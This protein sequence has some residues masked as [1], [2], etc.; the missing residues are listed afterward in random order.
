MSALQAG[1][2]VNSGWVF[3]QP[4]STYHRSLAS[5]GTYAGSA[6]RGLADSDRFSGWLGGFLILKAVVALVYQLLTSQRVGRDSGD[7][8]NID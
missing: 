6:Q 8:H 1:L 7:Q 2:C 5:V 4:L 3:L